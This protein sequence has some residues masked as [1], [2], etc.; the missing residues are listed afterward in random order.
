MMTSWHTASVWDWLSA[1]LMIV[2]FTIML[3]LA[4]YLVYA[5]VAGDGGRA[6]EDDRDLLTPDE[7]AAD[8]RFE[9]WITPLAS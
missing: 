2:G 3:C 6:P 7:P 9:G 5:L 1:S 8:A 4:S